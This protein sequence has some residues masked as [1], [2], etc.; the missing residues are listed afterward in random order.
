MQ[1]Q[2]IKNIQFSKLLKADG[3]LREFNFRKL[4][5]LQDGQT[6]TV[7]VSDERGNRILFRMQKLEDA[8]RLEPQQLPRWIRENETNLHELIEEQLRYE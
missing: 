4:N 8:W 2:T 3:R 1:V 6:F 5:G 7:D